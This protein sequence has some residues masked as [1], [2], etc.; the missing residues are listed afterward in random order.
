MGCSGVCIP[1]R[2]W[3]CC[4]LEWWH[5]Q[6]E[7]FS[8]LLALCVGHSPVTSDFPSQ[9]PVT[10]SFDVFFDLPLNKWLSKQPSCQWF[11]TPSCS[12]WHHCNEIYRY[13]KLH[14]SQY[15]SSF[16][17][18]SILFL[19]WHNEPMNCDWTHDLHVSILCLTH[20]IYFQI[21]MSLH[22]SLWEPSIV[23]QAGERWYLTH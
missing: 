21:M 10:R 13:Q 23:T 8:T 17:T 4:L 20:Y 11:E 16:W 5:H 12:L 1:T 19:T 15:I 3:F 2:V 14:Q 7:T 22:N 18:F 9:R 6:I